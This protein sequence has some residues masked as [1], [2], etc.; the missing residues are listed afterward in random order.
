MLY[1]VESPAESPQFP[2]S[3]KPP[4]KVLSC[5]Q[6]TLILPIVGLWR[7][8]N[9]CVLVDDLSLFNDLNL[10]NRL[11]VEREGRVGEKGISC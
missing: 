2:Q 7:A 9:M 1:R 10:E 5:V 4:L 3:P 8:G 6:K 11:G